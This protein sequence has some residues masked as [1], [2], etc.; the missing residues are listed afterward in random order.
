MGD[1][2]GR[3]ELISRRLEV[4]THR[5]P[6]PHQVLKNESDSHV[7]AVDSAGT[8]QCVLLSYFA[9]EGWSKAG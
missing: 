5:Y 2:L 1:D 3:C 6:F 4:C 7:E 9:G 8:G